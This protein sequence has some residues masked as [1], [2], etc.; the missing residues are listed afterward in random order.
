MTTS[1][2]ISDRLV[3][4]SGGA[5]VAMLVD[6]AT[7]QND[8]S[9]IAGIGTKVANG[10]NYSAQY[11]GNALG[12]SKL[13]TNTVVGDLMMGALTLNASNI[14]VGGAVPIRADDHGEVF[15][16]SLS[17]T[18]CAIVSASRDTL[19]TASGLLYKIIAAACGGIAG[20][21]LAVMNGG[22]SL[23]HVCFSQINETIVIDF[24]TGTC[25]ASL[26]TE[27]RNSTGVIF[28]TAIYK[29]YGMG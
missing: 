2:L 3:S 25:F 24:G 21:Q 12:G 29:Q 1:Y 5:K 23:T 7:S 11:A 15:V 9:L 20:A 13:E 27:K 14:G 6:L 22:L 8:W 18:A 26:V 4:D 19:A 28:T 16:S 10:K 17:S